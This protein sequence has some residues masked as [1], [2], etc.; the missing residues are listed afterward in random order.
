MIPSIRTSKWTTA[1]LLALALTS[2]SEASDRP[3]PRGVDLEATSPGQRQQASS[4]TDPGEN[5][6]AFF[7]YSSDDQ[8]VKGSDL[9]CIRTRLALSHLASGEVLSGTL[10]LQNDCDSALAVL[11]APVE[12]RLKLDREKRFPFE[13]GGVN[14]VY[15]LAYIFRKDL[16][17][18][19]RE[20]FL[21]DG[22]L[23]VST[24][25][26]YAVVEPAS[27]LALAIS[28]GDPLEI[29]PGEY[30]LALF[31]IVVQAPGRKEKA[32][33]IDFRES[34]RQLEA[35]RERSRELRLPPGAERVPSMGYFEVMGRR[36]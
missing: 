25:P 26:E 33:S 19:A 3:S 35:S 32:G 36:P 4:R 16:G 29:E 17:F 18:G 13:A 20:T 24:L 7:S 2:C 6:F 14:E 1:V 10:E 21:G 15:D 8:G 23:N 5:P 11:T 27:T 22:G 12:L 30:G 9:G 34:V 28:S 31:T